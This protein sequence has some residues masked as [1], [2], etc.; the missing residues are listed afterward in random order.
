[1]KGIIGRKIG[2]MQLF[3]EAGKSVPVTV[4]SA[5]PCTVTEIRTKDKN[6]YNAVQL[7]FGK[8]N[9]K[10]VTKPVEGQYKKHNLAV[11]K[12]LREFRVEDPSVY[13]IGQEIKASV[14]EAGQYVDVV[15]TSIGKGFAGGIKRHHFNGGPKSHG[16]MSHRKPCSGGATDAARTIKGTRKP[17]HMGAGRVTVQGLKVVR[18]DSD[19]N[20]L[21]VKGAVPGAKSGLLLIKESVKGIRTQNL[22]AVQPLH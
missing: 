22:S 6:G 1:M 13:E 18:V 16:S 9:M 5:G 12:H 19:K 4:I 21:V 20:L 15:G 3:D 8:A 10:K 14:F 17:G 2:M 11:L 7:G